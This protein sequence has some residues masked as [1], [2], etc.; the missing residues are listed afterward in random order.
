VYTAARE[1]YFWLVPGYDVTIIHA[2][3][4]VKQLALGQ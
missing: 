4:A 1:V 2:G 3:I